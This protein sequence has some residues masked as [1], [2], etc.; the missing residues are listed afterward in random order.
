MPK[1]PSP[2]WEGNCTQLI[3]REF[4]PLPGQRLPHPEPL[5]GRREGR[6]VQGG[7][8]ARQPG[9]VRQQ[10]PQPKGRAISHVFLIEVALL[11]C[12]GCPETMSIFFSLGTLYN[13]YHPYEKSEA[14]SNHP[15]SA[16]S[17]PTRSRQQHFQ[18]YLSYYIPNECFKIGFFS[19]QPT[20]V[21]GIIV[22]YT[23]YA[24]ACSRFFCSL[25]NSFLASPSER[26]GFFPGNA[27]APL[28]E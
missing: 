24:D 10:A 19:I 25:F 20:N 23:H 21:E 5:Q 3:K 15:R 14:S 8:G 4:L 9:Q 7:E 11:L 27:R 22:F 16:P 1:F 28:I 18:M 26:S 17:P 12:K 6:G 13:G 2:R